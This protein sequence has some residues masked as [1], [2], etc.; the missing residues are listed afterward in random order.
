MQSSALPFGQCA[1]SL[2]LGKVA[3]VL[4][5]VGAELRRP[6]GSQTE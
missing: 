5:V 2:V 1:I 6:P 4:N 3:P